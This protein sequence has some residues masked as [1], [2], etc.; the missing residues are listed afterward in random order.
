MG[1]NFI[2]F[3]NNFNKY[4]NNGLGKTIKGIKWL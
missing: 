4:L 3:N 2:Y 1:F